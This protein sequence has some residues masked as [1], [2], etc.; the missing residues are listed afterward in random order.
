MLRWMRCALTVCLLALG[1]A[2]QAP[3]PFTV[4]KLGGEP[5]KPATVTVHADTDFTQEERA[6]MLLAAN[7]WRWQTSGLAD[8]NVVFDLDFSSIQSLGELLASDEVLVVRAE[9]GSS[10]V[11]AADASSNCEGCVLGWMTS[12][13]IHAPKLLHPIQGAFIVS[14]MNQVEGRQLKVMLHEFGHLLGLPH[15]P[16]VQGIMYPASITDTTNCLK[17]SD[18]AL[19]CTVNECSGALLYPCE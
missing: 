5:T 17:K 13:G 9:E 8:I 1:C 11:L 2:R 3:E 18:L 6:D 14:R 10:S 7:I 15:S 12:G 16:S 4:G 19:F